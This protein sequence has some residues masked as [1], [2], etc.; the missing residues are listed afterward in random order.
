M[1]VIDY[2][3]IDNDINKIEQ[4]MNDTE[5]EIFH[6]GLIKMIRENTKEKVIKIKK[7]QTMDES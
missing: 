1:K 2:E 5:F 3:A 4:I 6:E 7:K